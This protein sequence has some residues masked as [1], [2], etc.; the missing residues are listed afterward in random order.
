MKSFQ[1]L[2]SSKK[3]HAEPEENKLLNCMAGVCFAPRFFEEILPVKSVLFLQS[4][5]AQ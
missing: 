5:T 4:Q 1:S 3:P 2:I